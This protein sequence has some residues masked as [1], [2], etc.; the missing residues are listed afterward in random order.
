MP[1][2][3]NNQLRNISRATFSGLIKLEHLNLGYN[4]LKSIDDGL[5]EEVTSLASLERGRE[6]ERIEREKRERRERRE[7]RERERE[8]GERVERREKRGGEREERESA[9]I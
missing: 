9:Y 5:F 6:R 4:A 8:R 2:L 3:S 7:K 1:H